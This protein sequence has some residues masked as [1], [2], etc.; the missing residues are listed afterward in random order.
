MCTFV[1]QRTEGSKHYAASEG[2]FGIA[3][4]DKIPSNNYTNEIL[5]SI[6]SQS[7]KSKTNKN[8]IDVVIEKEIQTRDREPRM[9]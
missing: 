8:R 9:Q 5:N 4:D 7:K 2:C 3:N 1:W 6:I